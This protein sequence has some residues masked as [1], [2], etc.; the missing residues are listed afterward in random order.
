MKTQNTF[1]ILFWIN[2]SRAKNNEADLFARITV[3]QKRVNISLKRKVSIESWDKSKSRL[4]GNGQEARALNNYID[5]TQ[6]AIF[7]A[8]QDLVSEN[9]L[10]T[11]QVIKARYLGIDQ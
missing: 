2:A 8:Y 4:K 9:K 7:K 5:Q 10:I 3:N 6:A 11:S 1:S